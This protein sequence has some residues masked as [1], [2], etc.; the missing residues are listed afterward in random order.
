MTCYDDFCYY[1][2]WYS[3][4]II[5][6]RWV[7]WHVFNCF[8]IISYLWSSI[9]LLFYFQK[10]EQHIEI[11]DKLFTKTRH[12][13]V[14]CVINEQGVVITS[15]STV[16]SL[17]NHF[18]HL[19]YFIS[20][21]T[22][23]SYWKPLTESVHLH[24]DMH[25]QETVQFHTRTPLHQY[26]GMTF[27]LC[28]HSLY[29]HI[30]IDFH[31]FQTK[32]IKHTGGR[33]TTTIKQDTEKLHDDLSI[34]SLSLNSITDDG[35]WHLPTLGCISY[36]FPRPFLNLFSSLVEAAAVEAMTEQH[37]TKIPQLLI[38]YGL[39]IAISSIFL[40]NL[41]IIYLLFSR[42]SSSSDDR[43]VWNNN[44]T[45][46]T[47]TISR[48]HS[49][50]SASTTAA[51][52]ST[53]SCRHHHPH[54]GSSWVDGDDLPASTP[55]HQH[56]LQPLRQHLKE[57]HV[58]ALG[59]RPGGLGWSRQINDDQLRVVRFIDDHLIQLHRCMHPTHIG[60]V[61]VK[62][63]KRKVVMPFYIWQKRSSFLREREKSTIEEE[64]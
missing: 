64:K 6:P 55:Y 32:F 43:M 3:T 31:I 12:T 16:R 33:T 59:L 19:V 60:L 62:T 50:P 2:S 56:S 46:L 20:F 7:G 28:P 1:F 4:Q 45:T 47:L 37:K 54:T 38:S 34:H 27:L 52:L 63:H 40:H 58:V 13:F 15:T 9:I 53:I 10:S 48:H 44:I 25:T 36:P 49:C 51:R 26:I 29:L 39:F 11:S 41:I 14:L 42:S 57:L 24:S 23:D 18:M 21:L 5:E 22:S 61:P 35:R 17:H 30:L 8:L